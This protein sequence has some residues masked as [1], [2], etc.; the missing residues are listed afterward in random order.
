MQNQSWSK[1]SQASL[2]KGASSN[3]SSLEKG[4]RHP[5]G[6]RLGLGKGRFHYAC[7]RERLGRMQAGVTPH[8]ELW[9]SKHST[10]N[11]GCWLKKYIYF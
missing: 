9:V 1:K 7:E 3:P 6:G 8:S 4:A 10:Q 5:D 2:Q 11:H